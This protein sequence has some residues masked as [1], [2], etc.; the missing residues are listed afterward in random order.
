MKEIGVQ[1]E[2]QCIWIW[3]H[4]LL[5]LSNIMEMI[6]NCVKYKMFLNKMVSTDN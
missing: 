5:L 3:F 2:Q 4:L 1:N 6:I